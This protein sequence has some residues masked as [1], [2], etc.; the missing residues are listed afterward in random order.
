MIRIIAGRP[1][2][3]IVVVQVADEFFAVKLVLGF[4]FCVKNNW[5]YAINV[6]R[7]EKFGLYSFISI[8]YNINVKGQIQCKIR[9]VNS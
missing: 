5:N 3:K 8:I 6:A 7:I 4:E 9:T 1:G 2:A